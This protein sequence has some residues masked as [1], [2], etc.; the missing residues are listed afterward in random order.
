MDFQSNTIIQ[1]CVKLRLVSDHVLF[2]FLEVA[3]I[4]T[5]LLNCAF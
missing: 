1:A 2:L 5:Q 4:A 3:I